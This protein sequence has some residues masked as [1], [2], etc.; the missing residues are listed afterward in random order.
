LR[1]ISVQ[2][3]TRRFRDVIAVDDLSFEVTDGTLFALLGEN[4]AGKSTTIACLSTLLDFDAGV[5]DIDGLTRPGDDHRIREQIGVVFQE[6]L[7]DPFLTARENL[8]LRASFYHLP[9]ARV[10]EL[11]E[12]IG[13]TDF[14]NRRYGVLSGGQKRR[15]DIARALLNRPRTLFLDEPTAGL[16]PGSR[17]QVWNSIRDLRE[18]LG[19]AVVLTTHY[20]Q[21]TEAA[22]DV[23]IIDHGRVL[24]QGT[25]LELRARHSTP[26]LLLAPRSDEDR[27]RIVF[28]VEQRPCLED[29]YE[30]GG[31]LVTSVPDSAT[32][33]ALLNE[34]S[35]SISDFQFVHGSMDDVF[36][37]LTARQASA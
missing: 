32:A 21:E 10:E 8:R 15:V 23:L 7:L 24:A 14:M 28:T 19:L 9:D 36:L 35:D 6:S 20:M 4:G 25:P 26:R 30:E 16:D 31:A 17:E 12:M 27:E 1:V 11:G 2:G 18:T 34:L 5:I 13:L 37:S 3:L 29:W 33:M 22:D